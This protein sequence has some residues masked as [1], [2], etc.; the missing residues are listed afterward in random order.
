M[1][2]IPTNSNKLSSIP[3]SYQQ[4]QTQLLPKF[5]QNTHKTINLAHLKLFMSEN[6]LDRTLS[7]PHQPKF[8]KGENPDQ[9][10]S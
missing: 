9:Q 6:S 5:E 2:K 1:N 3:Q 7:P 10:K 8:E 4:Q